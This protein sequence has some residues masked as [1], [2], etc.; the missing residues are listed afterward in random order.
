MLAV[1]LERTIEEETPAG[2]ERAPGAGEQAFRDVPW[3][4]MWTTLAQTRASSSRGPPSSRVLS[5][6]AGSER[7]IRSGSFTFES[8]A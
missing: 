2:A 1:A 5:H 6:Q 3:R 7:S 8:F 4:A